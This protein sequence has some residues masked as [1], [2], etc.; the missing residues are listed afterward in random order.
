M[1][2]RSDVCPVFWDWND[3]DESE[4]KSDGGNVGVMVG[5]H[6]VDEDG[7]GWVERSELVAG[8]R[9]WRVTLVVPSVLVHKSLHTGFDRV[10]HL[11]HH[12]LWIEGYT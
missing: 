6:P 12:L 9:W 2:W 7:W 3:D 1:G 8:L 11:L 4:N 5:S 10:L